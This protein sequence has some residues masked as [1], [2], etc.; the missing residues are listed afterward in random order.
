MYLFPR[1]EMGERAG[2]GSGPSMLRAYAH[3]MRLARDHSQRLIGS[4]T[5]RPS[6]IPAIS[7]KIVVSSLGIWVFRPTRIK[8]LKLKFR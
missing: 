1:N 6:R 2:H 5:M 7:F 4:H 3:E 8:F